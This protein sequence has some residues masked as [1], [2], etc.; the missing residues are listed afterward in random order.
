MNFRFIFFPV[1]PTATPTSNRSTLGSIENLLLKTR[2]GSQGC[3]T[4]P[5]HLSPSLSLNH[6]VQSTTSD[7]LSTLC[8][9]RGREKGVSVPTNSPATVMSDSN[10]GINEFSKTNSDDNLFFY[11]HK[12]LLICTYQ[13]EY[14][15]IHF[16]YFLL[17]LIKI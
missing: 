6:S 10:E 12:S 4:V 2:L 13:S 7:N 3:E 14:Q 5:S 15:L 1:G 11:K 17:F 8:L 16:F 9:E